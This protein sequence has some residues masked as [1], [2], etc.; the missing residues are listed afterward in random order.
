MIAVVVV[1]TV[2]GLISRPSTLDTTVTP[3]VVPV[4][5]R[6]LIVAVPFN[7][8]KSV[9]TVVAVILSRVS[10]STPAVAVTLFGVMSAPAT[11][12]VIPVVVPVTT[13]L[14]TVIVLAN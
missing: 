10:A 5:T 3:V 2:A 14:L 12:A 6:S 11:S 8:V 1:S 13:M 7:T 9:P 4:T